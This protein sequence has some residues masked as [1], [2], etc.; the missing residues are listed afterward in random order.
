MRKFFIC[1]LFLISQTSNSQ[2][3]P[4]IENFILASEQDRNLLVKRYFK[5][6]FNSVQVSMSEGWAKTAKTH[7]KLGFDFSFFLSG[8]NV[9]DSSRNFD[10]VGLSSISS[11]YDSNPTIFGGE[12]GGDYFVELYNEGNSSSLS[13]SFEA[14]NGHE[15]LLTNNRLI[16]PNLQFSLGLPFKTELI[17]RLMTKAETK[18]A[19]FESYG[20]G[21]KHSILQYLKPSESLPLNM[22]VLITRSKMSGAYSFGSYS[23][24]PGQNQSIDL[25]VSN[26]SVGLITS[27]DLSLISIYGSV[28]QVYSESSFEMK[29]AYNINYQLNSSPTDE[30]SVL[31]NNP[32]LFKNKLNYLK[33]NIGLSL[34]F[35]AVSLFVNYSVQE[36]NTINVGVSLGVR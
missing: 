3:F 9:P 19:E 2:N 22:S 18:G 7:K 17:F 15:D 12:S 31:L 4:G 33:K 35:P 6:L 27:L 34:N 16:L 32:V 23:E 24:I 11:T 10:L 25:N 29:G 14:P 36:L 21:I 8:V 5:P 20:F 1:I 13:A 28:S 26:N 30:V